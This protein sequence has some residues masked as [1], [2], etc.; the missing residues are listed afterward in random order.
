MYTV[1]VLINAKVG[2]EETV[3]KE[4]ARMSN[5]TRTDLLMGNYDDLAIVEGAD[6]DTLLG[7]ILQRVRAMP[8]VEKTETLVAREEIPTATTTSSPRSPFRLR[9]K[10]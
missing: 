2:M 9:K 8:G 4:L 7:G 6:L 5:V 1:Y 10:E 3:R